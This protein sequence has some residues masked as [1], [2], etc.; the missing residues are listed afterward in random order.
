MAIGTG[1]MLG[2]PAAFFQEPDGDLTTTGNV[3]VQLGTAFGFLLVPMAIAAWR[4]AA[5]LREILPGSGCAAS[6]LGPQVDG[7][8]D[9]RLPA[10][11]RRSTRC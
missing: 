1:I 8:R 4:G 9:R 2:I 5:T 3:L 10:L 6:A 11:R 7:G